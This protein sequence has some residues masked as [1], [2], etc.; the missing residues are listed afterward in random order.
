MGNDLTG[1]VVLALIFRAL[2]SVFQL[3]FGF[4]ASFAV[5]GLRPDACA[6]IFV[7]V[8]STGALVLD[9]FAINACVEDFADRW[10]G[11]SEEA[12]LSRAEVV[13]SFW[14]LCESNDV[15]EYLRMT[16]NKEQL[17][18][19]CTITTVNI[20]RLIAF[21]VFSDGWIED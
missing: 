20:E 12:I 16:F 17:T 13:L 15:N 14:C 18:Q 6:G 5:G 21:V 8:E 11:M 7:E 4:D 19:F 10:I 1:L 9:V 3:L 2:E